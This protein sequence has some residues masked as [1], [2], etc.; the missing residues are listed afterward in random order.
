MTKNNISEKRISEQKLR[1]EELYERFFSGLK[2]INFPGTIVISFPF[3]EISGKY[4]YFE[5]IYNIL[6]KYTEIQK[7]FP[8]DLKLETKV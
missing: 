6:D 8:Q 5:E 4:F 2:R 3:W 1:L 7:I